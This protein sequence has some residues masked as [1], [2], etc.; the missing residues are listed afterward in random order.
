[1]SVTVFC[2][3]ARQG[4]TKHSLT[5]QLDAAAKSTKA[6]RQSNKVSGV[7]LKNFPSGI[8][9]LPKVKSQEYGAVI[10]TLTVILGT[11]DKYTSKERTKV[12]QNALSGLHVLWHVLKRP[13]VE[14]DQL[15]KVPGLVSR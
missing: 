12:V 14:V 15:D 10:L 4:S 9:D 6:T 8:S 1:M 5:A 7:P 3:S 13:F 2:P 11:A